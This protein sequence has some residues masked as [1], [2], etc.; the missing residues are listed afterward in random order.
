[1][2]LD[3]SRALALL[4]AIGNVNSQKEFYLTDIVAIARSSGLDVAAAIAAE[5]E[6]L[7]VNDR[8]QLA[9]AE[10]ILQARLRAQAMR[11]GRDP[12][13]SAKRDFGI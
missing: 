6:V 7:G 3:G 5:D 13:R 2:A 12:D 9:A 10:A 4:G 8:A 11:E 1:M